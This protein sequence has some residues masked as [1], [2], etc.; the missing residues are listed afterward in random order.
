M[1]EVIE[2]LDKTYLLVLKRIELYGSERIWPADKQYIYS[3]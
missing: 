2:F 3:A 1:N